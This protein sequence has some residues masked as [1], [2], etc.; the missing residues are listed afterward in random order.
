MQIMFEDEGPQGRA[1][2]GRCEVWARVRGRMGR[3][4]GNMRVLGR[5][6]LKMGCCKT[7]S[8]IESLVLRDPI[9]FY[10]HKNQARTLGS[11]ASHHLSSFYIIFPY[12]EYEIPRDEYS[13]LSIGGVDT[14]PLPS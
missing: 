2:W 11:Q 12:F 9:Y 14:P 13:A 3:R 10:L 5:M 4:R 8:M 6:F 7:N 1:I